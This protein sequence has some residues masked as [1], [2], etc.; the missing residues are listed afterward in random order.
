MKIEDKREFISSFLGR[1]VKYA[2]LSLERKVERGGN[3]IEIS[4]WKAYRDFT[5]YS[6]SEVIS[7]ALDEWLDGSSDSALPSAP[8]PLGSEILST[9]IRKLS[10][11]ERR[12]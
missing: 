2:D 1:C 5:A 4:R 3:D 9:D 11:V 7:G 10:H 6:A 12:G 8:E